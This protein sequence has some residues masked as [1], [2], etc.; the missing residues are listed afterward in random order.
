MGKLKDI[1][2]DLKKRL[3]EHRYTHTESVAKTALKIYE[4]IDLSDY[5]E[6]SFEDFAKRIELG[7]WLHD[8]C[9]ELKKDELMEL[10]KFYKIKIYE[11]DKQA[12]NLLHARVGAAW[13]QDE[14]EIEDPY[15]FKA[16]EEHTFGGVDMLLSSKVVY[17]ADMIEPLRGEREILNNIRS[18]VF[19]EGL[20]NEPLLEAFNSKIT[21]TIQKNKP[22]H[23]LSIAARNSLLSEMNL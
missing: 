6:T 22:V 5:K 7:A 10:A 12:P 17:L 8:S 23:P 18:M 4:S 19:D 20:L 13:I 21:Y 14:Y 3:S 1:K 16:V 11:E 15:I 2:N 9:K